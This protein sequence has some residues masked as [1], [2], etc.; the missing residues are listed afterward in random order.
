MEGHWP[1]ESTLVLYHNS[2]KLSSPVTESV[3]RPFW[4][5]RWIA[6]PA[7]GGTANPPAAAQGC[8]TTP[9]GSV[10]IWIVPFL[11][12]SKELFLYSSNGPGR[13]QHRTNY[14]ETVTLSSTV[15]LVEKRRRQG[16]GIPDSCDG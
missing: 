12:Q 13:F 5:C 10:P 4:S 2:G 7:G 9:T 6:Y 16:S 8:W 11:G 1:T 14:K 3:E 15:S